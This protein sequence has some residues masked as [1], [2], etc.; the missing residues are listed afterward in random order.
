MGAGPG[1]G[2][3]GAMGLGL[4]TGEDVVLPQPACDFFCSRLFWHI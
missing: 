1:N 4:P 2:G 3:S